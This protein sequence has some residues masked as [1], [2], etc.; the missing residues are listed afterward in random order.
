MAQTPDFVSLNDVRELT[1]ITT[2]L[3]GD[4]DLNDIIAFRENKIEQFLN[5][6]FTPHREIELRDGNNRRII[7]TNKGPLLALRS[8]KSND[9]SITIANT[10]FKHTGKITLKT[11]S[12]QTTFS[13][14]AAIPNTIIIDYVYGRV[15]FPQ[16]SGTETTTDSASIVGSAIA[17]SVVSESNFTT[18]DWVEV[19]GTDGNREAAQIT[20]TASGT[21]TVDQL[22]YT[23]VS[24][25]LV[26][27]LELQQNV[28]ELIKLESA[29]TMI[30]RVIGQSFDEITG[31]TIGE[32]QVQKGEPF[33]QFR[34]SWKEIKDE[35][36]R[37]KPTIKPF[38]SIKVW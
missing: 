19:Y 32:R 5:T 30:G 26:R 7:F 17:L 38:P 16:R 10:F 15:S 34:E 8:L 25:S 14:F 4:D 22:L 3:V 21:I 36:A 27:K 23:H 28:K 24:G 35:W 31:Y 33:T 13:R 11:S 2:T 1:G 20:G 6:A 9:T 37:L 12:E 18:N 29:L